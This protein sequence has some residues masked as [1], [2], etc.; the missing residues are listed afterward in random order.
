MSKSYEPKNLTKDKLSD[1]L[2]EEH[3][4]T[5]KKEASVIVNK[6]FDEM[7]STLRNGFKK[8]VIKGLGSF[9][10]FDTKVKRGR[11]PKTGE[12]LLIPPMKK[13]R[14]KQSNNFLE[15]NSSNV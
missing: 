1:I 10:S 8:V 3:L 12:K 9:E 5:S 11:N 4:L 14:F 15:E 6:I 7:I 2:L 13:I